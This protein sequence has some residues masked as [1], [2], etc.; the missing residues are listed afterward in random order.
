[1]TVQWQH[2]D[3]GS[4]WT[5]AVTDWSQS[6]NNQIVKSL[7]SALDHR[8]W[9]V[10]VASSVNPQCTEVFMSSG[11]E[12]KV[13]FDEMP[14]ENDIDRVKWHETLGG[15]E[16]SVKMGDVRRVRKYSVF[17]DP[18]GV[19]NWS[20]V[21]SYLDENSKPFYV[22]DHEGNYWLARFKNGLPG[23]PWVTEQQKTKEIELLEIL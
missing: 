21:I 3:N 23:G 12:F 13:R 14:E 18:T 15:L 10:H 9:R 6:D 17:L 16:R 11:Y 20:T 1:M 8:Y 2:S 22:E 4:V 19:S 5:D 7:A